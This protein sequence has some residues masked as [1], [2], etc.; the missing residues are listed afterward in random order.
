MNRQRDWETENTY[1]AEIV[2]MISKI[3]S[4]FAVPDGSRI[5]KIARYIFE[6]GTEENAEENQMIAK[7]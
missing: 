6:D 1:V 7:V 4:E 2:E 3:V 5:F